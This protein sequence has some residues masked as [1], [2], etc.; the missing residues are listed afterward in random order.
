MPDCVAEQSEFELPVPLSKLSDN[1]LTLAFVLTDP[2]ARPART[3]LLP[4]F[5]ESVR[6]DP[7]R[8]WETWEV[9]KAKRSSSRVAF[10]GEMALTAAMGRRYQMR[11]TSL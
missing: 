10:P 7:V 4:R 5:V 9:G 1:S 11:R 2:S 6:G 3:R 8:A